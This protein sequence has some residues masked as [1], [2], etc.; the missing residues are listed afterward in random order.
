M[1]VDA[2]VTEI[3]RVAERIGCDPDDLARELLQ[4]TEVAAAEGG[5]IFGKTNLS[6]LM[7]RRAQDRA[8]LLNHI[9]EMQQRQQELYQRLGETFTMVQSVTA[10]L[11][12]VYGM[13]TTLEPI[14]S[15]QE[16]Q[17]ELGYISRDGGVFQTLDKAKTKEIPGQPTPEGPVK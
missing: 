2:L 8:N 17:K 3:Q 16:I 7:E 11:R 4:Q 1:N 6:R 10:H 12:K 5:F 15:F 14:S 9:R 13:S